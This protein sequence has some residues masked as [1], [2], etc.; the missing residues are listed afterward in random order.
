[1]LHI[2]S[3]SRQ[4]Y[5]YDS[6]SNSIFKATEP[7]TK[8][9]LKEF[10]KSHNIEFVSY[11]P[12]QLKTEPIVSL[13]INFSNS[14]NL[15]CK[16]CAY[17]GHYSHQRQHENRNIT[18]EL[19]LKA[20]DFYF[21]NAQKEEH[22]I[23]CYGGEPTLAFE[24]IKAVVAYAQ[25]YDPH[26]SFSVSTNF[27]HITDKQLE[28]FIKNNF[29]VF[30]SVDGPEVMHDLSRV[31]RAG[32]P[33]FNKIRDNLIRLRNLA[34]KFYQNNVIFLSTL[35]PPFNI[36]GIKALFD[37]DDLFH[38][39]NWLVSPLKVQDGDLTN[40]ANQFEVPCYRHQMQA[41]ADEYI[42]FM[43]RGNNKSSDHFG[44]HLFG[45]KLDKI[46]N[47]SMNP[48][49]QQYIHNCCHLGKT[50]LFVDCDGNFWPCE[51]DGYFIPMGNVHEGYKFDRAI[52]LTEQYRQAC[53]KMCSNC[54]NMRF[55][56]MCYLSAAHDSEYDFSQL[57]DM[58]AMRRSALKLTLY[59]MVSVLEQNPN[60]FDKVQ[61]GY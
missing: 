20:V 49:E 35:Q 23:R 54:D 8:D 58:C 11:S 2:Q 13:I 29:L 30:V 14:C 57:T 37:S 55:C 61:F 15:R 32:R 3:R 47:R 41:I 6:V 50:K 19:A 1:M 21:Q 40:I 39:H 33:T 7:L 22:L 18:T 38:G 53:E 31:D 4:H 17:S 36:M 43:I 56:D 45:Y 16:Y 27:Y 28:F 10:N 48:G 51:S 60:A 34:P 12:Q 9:E 52:E 26:T 5:Y 42:D 24:Q 59:I 44:H 46:L 25:S